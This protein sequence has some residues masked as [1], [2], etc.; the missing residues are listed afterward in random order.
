MRG[1]PG[2]QPGVLSAHQEVERVW[3]RHVGRRTQQ[4]DQPAGDLA[5]QHIELRVR[6]RGQGLEAQVRALRHEDA[7]GDDAM[8]MDVEIQRVAKSLNERNSATV[9]APD[10][11]PTDAAQLEVPNELS[12]PTMGHKDSGCWTG[13]TPACRPR[14]FRE[15]LLQALGIDE[16]SCS[17]GAVDA[18]GQAGQNGRS[19]RTV[20]PVT[21]GKMAPHSPL[22]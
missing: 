16:G 2:R 10:A 20:E 12:A 15:R 21:P 18:S 5:Q 17:A 19:G 11:L 9:A 13:S 14:S 4:A 7:V 8:E 1:L 6:R 22:I 3:L